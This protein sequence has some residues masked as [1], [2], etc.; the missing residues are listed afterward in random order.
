ML[1]LR[2]ES[3]ENLH[4]VDD[5]SFFFGSFPLIFLSSLKIEKP[6]L[7]DELFPPDPFVESG[8]VELDDGILKLDVLLRVFVKE[9]HISKEKLSIHVVFLVKVTSLWKIANYLSTC[10]D[11][12]NVASTLRVSRVLLVVLIVVEQVTHVFAL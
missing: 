8:I 3:R 4:G 9:L 7:N 12:G 11:G 2:V 1:L 6:S 10:L 5:I